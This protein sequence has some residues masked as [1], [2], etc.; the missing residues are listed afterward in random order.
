MSAGWMSFSERCPVPPSRGGGEDGF[1]AGADVEAPG[2]L[3]A[4]QSLVPGE[5]EEIDVHRADVEGD[6]AEGL[7]GVD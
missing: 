5:G 7:C 1:D 6:V 2:A 3:R 4:Q